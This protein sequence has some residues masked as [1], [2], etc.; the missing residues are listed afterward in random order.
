MTDLTPCPFCGAGETYFDENGFWSGDKKIVL[1][2]EIRHHCKGEDHTERRSGFVCLRRK[3]KD[4]VIAVWNA[5]T[6]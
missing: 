4:E 1:S 5:R 3:T 6:A 2:V